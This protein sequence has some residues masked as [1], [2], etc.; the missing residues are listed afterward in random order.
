[1][2]KINDI[3]NLELVENVLKQEKKNISK[4]KTEMIRD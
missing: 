3:K 2:N 1:M 4:V